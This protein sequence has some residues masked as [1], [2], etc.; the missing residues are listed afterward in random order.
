MI[1]CPKC[2]YLNPDG[3]EF[4]QNPKSCGT[5][6]GYADKKVAP[7]PGGVLLTV[8]PASFAVAPGSEVTVEVR[9]RNKSQVVDQYEIKVVGEPSRWTLAEP[10]TLSLFPDGEG[11]AKIRFRPVRSP[12]EPAGRKPFSIVVQSKASASVSAYQDGAVDVAPFQQPT[13]AI[14]PRTSRGGTSA[15]HRITVENQG[16]A[17]LQASLEGIDPD[18]L[19]T[20]NFDKPTVLVAPGESAYVQLVVQPRATFYDGPPQPHAF[21]VQ[22][23]AAGLPPVTTD[24]TMLQEPVARPVPRKFPLIPVLLGLLA[25]LVIGAVAVAH[26]PIGNL[27][28]QTVGGRQTTPGTGGGPASSPSRSASPSPS[29][30][31]TPVVMVNIPNVTCMTALPAEQAIEGAGFTF[32]G[33]FQHNGF[34]PSGSVFA[35]QPSGQAPKGSQVAA[36]ISSGPEPGGLVGRNP[37]LIIIKTLPPG[38]FNQFKI[39]PTPTTTP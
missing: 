14:V 9:V 39:N 17:P 37:C 28:A 3:T 15:S 4:C 21:K 13:L 26:E 16:N 7:L 27:I 32:A 29:P 5:F 25:V 1:E 24:V 30:S 31:P 33:K 18:D 10:P 36:L 12:E 35:T 6:V 20:F 19:L 23:R 38:F 11:E 34:Y 22:L 8:S 2:G